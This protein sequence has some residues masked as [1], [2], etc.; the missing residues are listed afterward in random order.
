MRKPSVSTEGGSHLTYVFFAYNSIKGRRWE[1]EK[2][3]ITMLL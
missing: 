3:F 2:E 1:E